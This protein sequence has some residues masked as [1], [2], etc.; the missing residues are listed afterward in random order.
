MTK[1]IR[2][3]V[4][5]KTI[6]DAKNDK[7]ANRSQWCF[8]TPNVEPLSCY[9]SYTKGEN[10]DSC[11]LNINPHMHEIFLQRYRMKWVSGDPLKE[12]IN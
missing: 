7:H 6:S 10:K 12:M 3:S 11:P 9:K 8:N 2:I 5:L 4:Q 1:Y